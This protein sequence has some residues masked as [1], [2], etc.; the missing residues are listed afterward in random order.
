MFADSYKIVITVNSKKQAQCDIPHGVEVSLQIDSLGSYEPNTYLVDYNYNTTSKIMMFCDD[1]TCSQLDLSKTGLLIIETKTH[2]TY[3]KVGSIKISR[4][5]A[6]NCF[7]DN[8]FY[9]EF[10][11]GAIIAKMYAT[12]SCLASLTYISGSDIRIKTPNQ[13]TFYIVYDDFSVNIYDSLTIQLFDDIVSIPAGTN[14]ASIP[15]VLKLS[16]SGISD[17]FLQNMT[18]GVQ[19][20]A[21]RKTILNFKFEA[22]SASTT[23]ILKTTQT[24]TNFFFFMGIQNAYQNI[25]LQM[26]DNGFIVRKDKGP[27]FDASNALLL[28]QGVTSYT[29]QYVFI[30][31]NV[32]QTDEFWF[33]FLGSGTDNFL[34]NTD[35]VQSTCDLRFPYQNCQEMTR[36]I[37]NY[38]VKEVQVYINYF[39]YKDDQV[40]NN[41][42]VNIFT[43][44][45]SCFSSGVIDYYMNNK[46]A[47]ISINLNSG[48]IFCQ[49]EENDALIVR[50]MDGNGTVMIQEQDLDYLPGTQK[51]TFQYEELKETEIRVQFY[52]DGDMLEA[53]SIQS[54]VIHTT[55]KA[56]NQS[57]LT[58]AFVLIGNIVV[59]I[60]YQVFTIC[61]FPTLENSNRKIIQKVKQR[62]A[63]QYKDEMCLW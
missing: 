6:T 48:S 46:T 44:S 61:V 51:I 37:K 20:K 32:Y 18:D 19:T 43:L 11:D 22:D 55:S 54:F 31:Y 27:S 1:P 23:P 63:L 35:A 40:I 38:S 7:N 59:L 17:H 47:V 14:E 50:I 4:G 33:S 39:F 56:F 9:I 2:I 57:I 15:I 45:D 16:Q 21:I 58:V 26:L 13:A 52:K 34:L 24:V 25:T 28:Q 41:L 12:R 36:Q 8:D 53:V 60:F 10:Y 30:L 3:V 49:L 62:N 42:T 29:A 5:N